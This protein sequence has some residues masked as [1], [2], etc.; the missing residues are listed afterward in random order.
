MLLALGTAIWSEISKPKIAYVRTGVLINKFLGMQEASEKYEQKSAARQANIDSLS[1]TLRKA[2]KN[3]KTDSLGMPD[4]VK[5]KRESY[6]F[7]LQQGVM[8]YQKAAADMAAEQEQNMTEGI[9][10]QMNGYIEQYGKDHGYD[11]ILGT[12]SAGNLLYGHEAFDIT[13]EVLEGLNN[14]YKGE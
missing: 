11:M 4:S 12:T 6:I 2:I 5:V 3:Y 1:S 8:Q 14:S 10:N 9:L 13:D 7:Q